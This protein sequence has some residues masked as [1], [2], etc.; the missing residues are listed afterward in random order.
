MQVSTQK[1]SPGIFFLALVLLLFSSVAIGQTTITT[2]ITLQA[3]SIPTGN[4]VTIN[5]NGHLNMD[6]AKTFASITTANAGNSYIDG[7]GALTVTGI[8]TIQ[9]GNTLYLN[10]NCTTSSLTTKWTSTTT[11]NITGNGTLTTN[12]VS[13]ES[14]TTSTS[15]GWLNLGNN[16]VCNSINKAGGIGPHN[17]TY[18]RVVKISGAVSNLDIFRGANN[19]I[20]TIEYNGTGDQTVFPGEY[21]FLTVSATTP[22]NITLSPSGIIY[23]KGDFNHNSSLNNFII[24]GSTVDFNGNGIQTIPAIPYYNLNISGYRTTRNVTMA[25]GTISVAG[26]FSTSN[27]SFTTGRFIV[28]GNTV[29]LNGEG[30]NQTISGSNVVFNNLTINSSGTKSFGSSIVSMSGN[31]FHSAG[32]MDAGTSTV[33]FTGTC[34]IDGSSE[35]NFNHFTISNTGLVSIPANSGVVNINGNFTNNGNMTADAATTVSFKGSKIQTLSGTGT[36]IF[37]NINLANNS[38]VNAGSHNIRINGSSFAVSPGSTFNGQTNTVTVTGAVSLEGAGIY[39]FNHLTLAG[40]LTNISS[41]SNFNLSGNWINNG[42]YL[43]GTETITLN[44]TGVQQIGGLN[45]TQ[46]GKEGNGGGANQ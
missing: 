28:T 44:G 31:L 4:T 24:T 2:G 33:S 30:V 42:S 15:S 5:A 13:I 11:A 20:A 36:T 12:A 46:F 45:G 37:G 10:P 17:L 32:I 22:R 6:V 8:I 3:S 7:L 14:G 26:N 34:S 19:A 18:D 9:T 35:K 29:V 38:T 25:P 43:P 39:N 23:I 16:V 41:N 40:S 1:W 27:S 21:Y